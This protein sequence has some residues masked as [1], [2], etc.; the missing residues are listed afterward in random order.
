MTYMDIIEHFKKCIATDSLSHAYLLWGY[1]DDDA[2]EAVAFAVVGFFEVFPFSDCLVVRSRAGVIGIDVAREV[3]RFLWARPAR[4]IKRTVVITD[5]GACTN[6][7]QNALLKTVEEPP[8][9]GL[10]LFIVRD[11]AVLVLAL[12]S[13]LQK[14]YIPPGNS[15]GLV[16]NSADADFAHAFITGSPAVRKDMVK[17]FIDAEDSVAFD[18]FAAAVM[19]CLA[20][21]TQKNWRALKE[22]SFRIAVMAAHPTNRRLQWEAISSY[23]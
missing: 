4:S 15:G 1:G 14:I 20:R 23:L 9:H 10:L 2:K 11:P 13:R 16:K 19:A 5:A 18:R 8:P 22:L 21:D 3:G 6:E 12:Q 17:R 7:A